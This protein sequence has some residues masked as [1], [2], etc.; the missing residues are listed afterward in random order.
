MPQQF[1]GYDRLKQRTTLHRNTNG[2]EDVFARRTFEQITIGTG[3][4][5]SY[6]ALVVIESCENYNT[7]ANQVSLTRMHAQVLAQTT[8]GFD[9]IHDWHFKVEQED[10]RLQFQ[11]QVQSFITIGSLLWSADY[12]EI[13]LS[14]QDSS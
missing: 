8:N 3:F 11:R 14:F 2:I 12:F 7:R 1:R 13:W 5:R 9:A 4:Q 10:I 6:D